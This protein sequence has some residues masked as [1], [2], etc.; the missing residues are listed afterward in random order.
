MSEWPASP[1]EMATRRTSAGPPEQEQGL[2]LDDP[3][4]APGELVDRDGARQ[5]SADA[6]PLEAPFDLDAE[7]LRQLGAVTDLRVR[8]ECEVVRGQGE[9]RR[10]ERLQAAALAPVDDQRFV[11]P[12]DPVVNEQQLRPRVGRAAE[13][14]ERRRDAAREPLDGLGAEHLGARRPVLRPALHLEQL[15]GEREDLVPARHERRS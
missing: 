14:L 2:A 10:E 8:V 12:E 6:D 11:A 7:P 3:G 13:E 1:V 5:R 15:V 4:E 9:I